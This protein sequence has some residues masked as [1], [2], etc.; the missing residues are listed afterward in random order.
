MHL[1]LKWTLA[2]KC[3]NWQVLLSGG[4]HLQHEVA[5]LPRVEPEPDPGRE[6]GGRGVLGPG[7]DDLGWA[8]AGGVVLALPSKRTRK[9]KKVKNIWGIGVP[10]YFP[11]GLDGIS[12][13]LQDD[14]VGLLGLG[15][16]VEA[17][18]IHFPK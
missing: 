1:R 9:Y 13:L 18:K 12:A 8:V 7:E 17:W 2:T 4:S 3:P 6:L 11:L 16:G 15:P 10:P 5:V 14:V